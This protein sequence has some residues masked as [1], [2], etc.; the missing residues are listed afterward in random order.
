MVEIGVGP[1]DIDPL[2][3]YVLDITNTSNGLRFNQ[4]SNDVVTRPLDVLTGV[5][6]ERFENS[7]GLPSV[8]PGYILNIIYDMNAS[9]S[10][11][12][13]EAGGAARIGDPLDLISAGGASLVDVPAVNDVPEPA[14]WLLLSSGLVLMTVATQRRRKR[15]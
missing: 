14:T 5:E 2:F 10:E 3:N 6:I 8:L 12:R 1:R 9:F 15:A 7:I 11:P 4:K 13:F